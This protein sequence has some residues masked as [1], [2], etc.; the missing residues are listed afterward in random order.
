MMGI[1]QFWAPKPWHHDSSWHWPQGF[2]KIGPGCSPS[3][4]QRCQVSKNL[5]V[6]VTGDWSSLIKFEPGKSEANIALDWLSQ[7]RFSRFTM[8]HSYRCAASHE[9]SCIRAKRTAVWAMEPSTGDRRTIWGPGW[10]LTYPSEKYEFVSWDDDMPNICKNQPA[11]KSRKGSP[12]EPGVLTKSDTCS[13]FLG[14]LLHQGIRQ[15][16]HQRLWHLAR[17]ARLARLATTSPLFAVK[18]FTVD[19]SRKLMI[20]SGNLT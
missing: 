6:S 12:A 13:G 18:I 5:L 7:T 19:G 16:G 15:N 17:L 20:P 2:Q 1:S 4:C 10:W 9:R 14:D 8:F 3:S 11:S